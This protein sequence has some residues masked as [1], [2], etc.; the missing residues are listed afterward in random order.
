MAGAAA[1]SVSDQLENEKSVAVNL[2]GTRPEPALA[3]G[4]PAPVPPL[5]MHPARSRP[6][7]PRPANCSS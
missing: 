6:A 1:S 7:A 4:E 5:G 3:E 2:P